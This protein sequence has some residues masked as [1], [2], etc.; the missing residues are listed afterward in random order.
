M[1]RQLLE[2]VRSAVRSKSMT[3]EVL[4]QLCAVVLGSQMPPDSQRYFLSA[5]FGACR[6]VLAVDDVVALR[7]TLCSQGWETIASLQ[8]LGNLYVAGT[9]C[10]S[11]DSALAEWA[12]AKARHPKEL[13]DVRR[14][15]EEALKTHAPHS[16][17]R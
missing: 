10:L 15:I 14:W 4:Q 8:V 17:F 12:A 6:S 1:R 9:A 13:P 16:A 5:A 7:K 3:G 11:R 2:Q